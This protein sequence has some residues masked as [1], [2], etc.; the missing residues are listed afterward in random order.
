M[1]A[2]SQYAIAASEEALDDA[3]WHPATQDEKDDM[4]RHHPSLLRSRHHN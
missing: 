3:G 2:F 4:V 1:A